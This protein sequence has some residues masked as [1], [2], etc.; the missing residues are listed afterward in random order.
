MIRPR[1]AL[2]GALLLLVLVCAAYFRVYDAG[3]VWDDDAHVTENINLRSVQGLRAIWLSPASGNQ[4]VPIQYYPMVH[5]TF[6]IEH[7]LWN[8]NPRGYHIVNVL[9][10]AANA[11]L[12]WFLLRRLGVRGAYLAAL[13]FA[14]HPVHVES[15]AWISERKNVLSAFFY[16]LSAL[17]FLRFDQS[18][19]E[20]ENR[21]WGTYLVSLLL[22]VAALLSRTVT[23][24]L[25]AA[26]LLV[27]WWRKGAISK[28]D[29]LS[30]IPMILVALP[31]ALITAR[32]EQLHVGAR[33]TY[34]SLSFLQRMLVA[35]RALWFYTDKLIWPTHLSFIYPRW[36][37]DSAVWPLYL[38]PLSVLLIIV[39]LW[40]ARKRIGRGPLVAVL[41]FCGTLFPALGFFN[42]FPMIYSF[43]ADHFQYL[44]SIGLITLFAAL[45]SESV[46]DGARGLRRMT[47]VAVIL[48]VAMGTGTCRRT[49]AYKDI[50]TL[51]TNT[52]QENPQCWMAHVNLG[53]M[54]SLRG[55]SSR[56]V[57]HYRQALAIWPGDPGAH[58]N[59]AIELGQA[60]MLDEAG[61]H[62][63]AAIAIWPGFVDARNNYG[64]LLAGRGR[65]DEAIAQFKEVVRMRPRHPAALFH[66]ASAQAQ[67]GDYAE[68]VQGFEA[69]LQIYPDDVQTLNNLAWTLATC[70]EGGVRDAKAAV[71]YAE[72]AAKVTERRQPHVLDTLAAAYAARG[73]FDAA[74]GT[75]REALAT[76]EGA[77][78]KRLADTVRGHIASFSKRKTAQDGQLQKSR[79]VLVPQ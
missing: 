9:F 59:L 66:L 53:K 46:G 72:R 7:Q 74:L 3:F 75:A 79:T 78:D 55:E 22:F 57:Q 35:G 76:A 42:V 26:L 40:F 43:V 44:A 37:I 38:Y 4:Y 32:L 45:V 65:W 20:G 21:P 49:G 12:L 30:V 1:S 18:E 68:A 47:A 60:G 64:L 11:I 73:Q 14:L 23:A 58:N 54:L 6:W 31:L 19:A 15:V 2:L 41:F 5:T 27:A 33:G 52:L 34:W 29:V 24:S 63:A 16:L 61:Q 36:N 67:K 51:W 50:E 48:A 70:P 25:P 69:L 8:N 13:I 77:G 62:F 17:A 39:A 28:K 10:H 71:T 56:A